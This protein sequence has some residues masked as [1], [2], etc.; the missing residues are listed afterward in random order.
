[1]PG[2]KGT[3]ILKA[4]D[5]LDSAAQSI[6]GQARQSNVADG[7][8]SPTDHLHLM[9]DFG[10][11]RSLIEE[12]AA[13]LELGPGQYLLPRILQLGQDQ[14]IALDRDPAVLALGGHLGYRVRQ[15]DI[16][17]TDWA[18]VTD[19]V[20]AIFCKFSFNAFWFESGKNLEMSLGG[21]LDLLGTSGWG[22][23][24]PW[25]AGRALDSWSRD[26][27]LERLAIMDDC[28]EK[29]NW[30]RISLTKTQVKRYGLGSLMSETVAYV[31]N[32]ELPQIQKR[33][34]F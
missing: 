26:E 1:M 21:L 10:I 28:F 17:T 29:H 32:L 3:V 16:R 25:N 6:I 22:W 13:I 7:L 12:R 15:M 19:S 11:S 14:Y 27:R 20:Q 23:F 18:T 30:E 24:A 33:P 2:D 8:R 5:P 9:R 4:P 31:K 34:W